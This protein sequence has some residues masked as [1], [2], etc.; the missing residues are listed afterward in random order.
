LLDLYPIFVRNQVVKKQY[1]KWEKSFTSQ[2]L[3]E[4]NEAKKEL[5]DIE[6]VIDFTSVSHSIESQSYIH[7]LG[8][9]KDFKTV[10]LQFHV[11]HKHTS[12]D[13]FV[14]KPS[15]V[16]KTRVQVPSDTLRVFQ[17]ENQIALLCTK[18]ILVFSLQDLSVLV[19]KYSLEEQT[20]QTVDL[21]SK[22]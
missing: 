7:V 12:S 20:I 4:V 10:L 15:L 22:A 5:I 16:E 3:T 1:P 9:D 13:R 18:E 21:A 17:I 11:S 8:V 6:R 14:G 2:M 19:K